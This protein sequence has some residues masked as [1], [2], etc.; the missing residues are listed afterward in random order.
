M[1]I[2]D[3]KITPIK[4][5][6]DRYSDSYLFY[7]TELWLSAPAA[8]SNPLICVKAKLN[9]LNLVFTLFPIS[10]GAIFIDIVF[11][12]LYFSIKSS[13]SL[14]FY[15]FILSF[16]PFFFPSFLSF[17][18]PFHSSIFFSER[19][20]GTLRIQWLYPVQ[21]AKIP[22]KK[23]DVLDMTQNWWGCCSGDLESVVSFLRCHQWQIPSGLEW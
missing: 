6:N 12:Y 8:L 16:L 20:V 18:S 10:L 22:Q 4:N 3:Y 23:S 13:T 14:W 1:L 5:N 7:H 19:P 11:S 21:K 9:L 17:F 2:Y 15:L